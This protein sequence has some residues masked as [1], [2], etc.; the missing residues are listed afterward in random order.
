MENGR[1][2][3]K[4]WFEGVIMVSIKDIAR[5][6][7]VSTATV[8]KALNDREDVNAQTRERIRAAAKQLGYLPNAQAR[9]LKTNK[10]YNIGVL[11]V[12]KADSGLKHYYFAS[13]LDSFKVVMEHN[14]YDLTFISTQIGSQTCTYYEHC[15]YRNVDGVLAACVEFTSPAVQELLKRELPVVSVDYDNGRNYAVVS[16]NEA[17]VRDAVEYALHR[18]HTKLAMICGEDSQVTSLRKAAFLETLRAHQREA[19]KHLLLNGK[20]LH[21]QIAY[22][23]TAALLHEDDRPDCILY[24]DDIC[25]VSGMAAIREAGLVPG[26]DVSVIGYD[27]NPVLQMFHPHLTTV[28]QDTETLGSQA[29]KLMLR[30]LHK[31]HIPVSER[32]SHVS[33]RL[34]EG[35][36][37]AQK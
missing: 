32:I 2:H 8:S 22:D 3:N 16:D 33:G 35:E 14:G 37:V 10:T 28:Q 20:Y 11:M 5:A 12:D 9:S 31:E 19:Q 7:G 26:E 34:L 29:A 15:M 30:L 4:Q 6:C 17:G 27:G 18:G 23:L 21:P 36:T 25:A 24:P 13:I 1:V